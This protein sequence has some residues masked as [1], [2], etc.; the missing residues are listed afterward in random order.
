MKDHVRPGLLYKQ[1]QNRLETEDFIQ[2]LTTA[3]QKHKADKY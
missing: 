2:T 1:D 3:N